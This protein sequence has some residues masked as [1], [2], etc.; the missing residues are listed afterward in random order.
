MRTLDTNCL[1]RIQ[2]L[3]VLAC[4]DISRLVWSGTNNGSD[5]ACQSRKETVR[6]V[7]L[8]EAAPVHAAVNK[9]QGIRLS[10]V[11]TTPITLGVLIFLKF[12]GRYVDRVTPIIDAVKICVM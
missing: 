9:I 11:Q 3:I 8:L 7:K 10:K 6:T 4:S 1:N 2:G 5:T 12:L